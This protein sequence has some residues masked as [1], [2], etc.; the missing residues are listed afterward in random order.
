M[1]PLRYIRDAM[2]A[3]IGA[4]LAVMVTVVMYE[5]VPIGPLRYIPGIHYVIPE[6]RVASERRKALEGYVLRSQLDAE[7]AKTA[8]IRR[9][10]DG[11]QAAAARYAMLMQE[12]I[13]RE[14]ALIESDA[15]KD[16]EYEQKLR[17]AGRRCEFDQS[18]IDWLRN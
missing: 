9:Q 1:N 7:R 15:V 2:S 3:I 18:D 5:G 12:A 10:L 14:Q 4:A 13:A 16:A 11:A 17:E 8:E 6:G